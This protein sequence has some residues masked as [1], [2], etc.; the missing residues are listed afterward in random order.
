MTTNESG[1]GPFRPLGILKMALET[2]GFEG[3]HCYDD[4]VFN[5]ESDIEKLFYSL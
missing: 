1:T 5:T 3:S 4:L 2:I